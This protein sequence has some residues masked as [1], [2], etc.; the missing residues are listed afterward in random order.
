[1]G[2]FD[3]V[4]AAALTVHCSHHEVIAAGCAAC[5]LQARINADGVHV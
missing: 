3:V 4:A 5:A 1:M 2:H